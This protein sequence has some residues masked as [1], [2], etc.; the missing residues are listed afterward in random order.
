M[1]STWN[2][3]TEL[4]LVDQ[5]SRDLYLEYYLGEDLIFAVGIT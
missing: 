2:I 5:E 3:L 4:L 1:T